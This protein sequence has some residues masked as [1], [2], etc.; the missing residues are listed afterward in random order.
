LVTTYVRSFH[1]P[2]RSRCPSPR[3]S[4]QV[5]GHVSR[6]TTAAIRLG[7][8][9]IPTT[10]IGTHFLLIHRVLQAFRAVSTR[11]P[12]G[13]QIGAFAR[14]LRAFST[15]CGATSC[16]GFVLGREKRNGRPRLWLELG[17][18][19]RAVAFRPSASV[20]ERRGGRSLQ[21]ITAIAAKGAGRAVELAQM[22]SHNP[23]QRLEFVYYG[24]VSPHNHESVCCSIIMREASPRPTL[25]LLAK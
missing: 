22:E 11:R 19:M 16:H 25:I 8:R 15:L 7:K 23:S 24:L 9:A 10:P 3:Q 1:E 18:R 5:A 21:S 4:R 14:L 12:N 20:T 13:R 17:R 6:F 2:R